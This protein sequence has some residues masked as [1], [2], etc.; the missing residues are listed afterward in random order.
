[1]KEKNTTCV[2]FTENFHTHDQ[3]Q[4]RPP[5]TT[6]KDVRVCLFFLCP[7][8]SLDLWLLKVD[9]RNTTMT[10]LG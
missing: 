2:V 4:D 1:M 10:T 8:H 6:V 7:S 3:V 5:G 9:R